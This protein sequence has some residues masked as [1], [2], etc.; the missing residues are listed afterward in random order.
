ALDSKLNFLDLEQIDLDGLKTALS[1][2][3]GAVRVKPFSLNYKDIAIQV[4]GSHGFDR[5][6]DYKATLEV[7]AKYLGSEV[8]NLIAQMND[9]SLSEVT[10]PVTASIGGDFSSP[11]VNTDLASSVKTLTSK[12][13]EV[14]KQKLMEQGKDKAKDL[15]SDLLNKDESDSTATSTQGGVKEA[16]GNL[17][18]GDKTASDTTKSSAQDQGKEAAKSILGGLLGKK[19]K[20]TV[21]R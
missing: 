10:V 15:L 4:D 5:Q 11:S 7:P 20:D 2:D 18:G 16:L 19:K 6:M 12:L 13:V 9:Q 3:N 8:G 21:D 14:Q 1:F 17:L